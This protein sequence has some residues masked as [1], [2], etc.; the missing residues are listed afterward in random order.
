MSLVIGILSLSA[1]SFFA[2]S[3]GSVAAFQKDCNIVYNRNYYSA[4]MSGI[5]PFPM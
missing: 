5:P 1:F 2:L 4:W 3:G